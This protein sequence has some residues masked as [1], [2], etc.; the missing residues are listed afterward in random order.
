MG[1]IYPC[2]R[3]VGKPQYGA[4]KASEL[5]W[6]VGDRVP[7]VTFS[8]AEPSIFIEAGRG[9]TNVNRNDDWYERF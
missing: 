8:W 9:L 5:G 1:T 7:D 4:F 6:G 2:V 3:H